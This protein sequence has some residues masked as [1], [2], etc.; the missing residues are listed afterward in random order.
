MNDYYVYL[1]YELDDDNNEI[2]FYVGKGHNGRLNQHFC[3]SLYNT[4]NTPVYCKIR[5]LIKKGVEP[6]SK[7]ILDGLT[8]EQAFKVEHDYIKSYGTR[9]DENYI[10]PLLNMNLGGAG[11]VFP[12]KE[13]RK[14]ISDSRKGQMTGKNNPRFGVD[15]KGENN[16]FYGC[17]HTDETKRRMKRQYFMLDLQTGKY[18]H[19]Y[20]FFNYFKSLGYSKAQTQKIVDKVNAGVCVENRYLVFKLTKEDQEKDEYWPIVKMN[21]LYSEY[22]YYRDAC[23]RN[24]ITFKKFQELRY[25]PTSKYPNGL[26]NEV[27]S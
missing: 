12:S 9:F 14:K 21:V 25:W 13:V 19:I 23:E 18:L 7:I 22:H 17:K 1:L 24:N 16:W 8:E 2:P 20:D 26:Y 5:S 3:P 10:G 27:T 11:G 15:C 6:K 4:K